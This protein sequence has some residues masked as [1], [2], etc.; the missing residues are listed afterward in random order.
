M[1][2]SSESVGN[3]AVAGATIE[4]N[5]T[6][7]ATP[8]PTATSGYQPAPVAPATT[9][10]PV[11]RAEVVNT[12]P[13]GTTRRTSINPSPSSRMAPS[14]LATTPSNTSPPSLKP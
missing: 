13:P 12:F 6:A 5:G 4:V 2:P 3:S 7:L 1:Q 11:F 14:S 8:T 9:P 10:G